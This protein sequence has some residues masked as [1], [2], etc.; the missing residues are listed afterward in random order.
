MWDWIKRK[1]RR[2]LYYKDGNPTFTHYATNNI[3]NGYWDIKALIIYIATHPEL[4]PKYARI[5]DEGYIY[6]DHCIV[7]GDPET[8]EIINITTPKE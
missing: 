1:L 4:N 7:K 8:K 2:W 6:L 5:T 3:I